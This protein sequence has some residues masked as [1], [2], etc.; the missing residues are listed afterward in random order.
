LD[1]RREQGQATR[2]RLVTA[3]S[4]LFAAQGYDG[5]SI[6]AILEEAHVSRGSLYHHFSTK[7]ALFEAVLDSVETRV[8]HEMMGAVRDAADAVDALRR[9]CLA[10]VS[11]AGDPV[12]QRI[13]LID[14]P[15]VLSWQRW[16]EIEEQY[17]LGLLKGGML[18]AAREGRL[19]AELVDVFA[20]MVLATMNELALVIVESDDQ[21]EAQRQ[22]ER[23]VNEY[24]SRLF[25]T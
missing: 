23:A 3:A 6:E 2:D 24:I 4:R 18:L 19:Q 25:V 5:T 15:A 9:G 13:V 14:A 22:A 21:E 10:W 16:R 1:K 11:L 7:Q 8:T 12:V 17:G 20:H